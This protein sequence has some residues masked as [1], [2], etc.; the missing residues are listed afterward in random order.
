MELK[1]IDTS[2][3]G[4]LFRSRLEARWAVFFDTLKLEWE[5]EPEGYEFNNGERYLPDFRIKSPVY[6]HLVYE[7]V[8]IKPVHPS[9][10]ELGKLKRLCETSDMT[11]WL[12]FGTPG[13]SR[14]FMYLPSPFQASFHNQQFFEEHLSYNVIRFEYGYDDE[15]FDK[16]FL[17]KQRHLF[18][19]A[20]AAARS[21]RFEHNAKRAYI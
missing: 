21:A 14:S 19:K 12:V 7:W 11:S 5:Y 2:Y 17:T 15:C 3:K 20:C 4:Y 6:D 9:D 16:S 13:N 8:E 1:A 10:V 18:E